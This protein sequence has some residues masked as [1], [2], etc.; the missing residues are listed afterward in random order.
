MFHFASR[1]SVDKL[2]IWAKWS[3][4]IAFLLQAHNVLAIDSIRW[5]G[6]GS[7]CAPTFGN[8]SY[9]Y[10]GSWYSYGVDGPDA[11]DKALF[12]TTYDYLGNSWYPTYIHFG[13]MTIHFDAP[14]SDVIVP[15][16]DAVCAVAEVMHGSWTFD[17]DTFDAPAGSVT[18]NYTLTGHFGD[19]IT[20]GGENYL[21]SPGVATLTV[22][23]NG[24]LTANRSTTI[25][26]STGSQGEMIVTG[27]T[28]ELVGVDIT[29][30]SYGE[31]TLRVEQQAAVTAS[32]IGY[33]AR[34]ASGS[35][36]MIVS[37][38]SSV[39]LTEEIIVGCFGSGTLSVQS[40]SQVTS[41]SG[42]IGHN[43]GA[44]GT[45]TV[46]G[47][48]SSW[49]MAGELNVGDIGKGTLNITN[50][51]TV[52]SGST[53]TYIGRRNWWAEAFGEAT[54]S[55]NGSIWDASA[56]NNFH[57]GYQG[58]GTLN[59]EQGGEV[60]CVS[61][62][63]GNGAE[64]VG[65]VTVDNATWTI[66][67]DLFVGN[68]G[69]GTLTVRNNGSVVNSD[70]LTVGRYSASEMAVESGG[71]VSN[72]KGTVA[73]QAG[74]A[75]TVTVDGVG[76]TWTSGG[77][78]YVG[79]HGNGTLTIQNGGITT[80]TAG[81]IACGSDS[82]STV[83]VNGNGS[84]WTN[85]DL[86][87]VGREGDGELMIQ[88]GGTVSNTF[89]HVGAWAGST[90]TVTVDGTNSEWNN[91]GTL[92]IGGNGAGTLT[93]QNGGTV[94]NGRTATHY[95]AAAIGSQTGSAG[96]VTIDGAGT[97]WA[98]GEDLIVANEGTGTLTVR[99]SG[100]VVNSGELTVGRYNDGEML[101]ESGATLSNTKGTIAAQAGSVGTVTVDGNGSTWTNTGSLFVG[102]NSNG[103]LSVS[104]GGNVS[105]AN[106]TIAAG[107]GSTS[108]VTISDAASLMSMA[109][110]TVGKY[111]D[112]TLLVEQQAAVTA[113]GFANIGRYAGGIGEM[114]VSG[115]SSVDFVERL[116]VGNS[117]EGTLSVQSNSL[118][119]SS[120][121]TIGGSQGSEGTANVSGSGTTWSMTG[122]L[123]VGD[124]GKGTLSITN[125]GMVTCGSNYTYIG[126]RNYWAEAFG[127]VN[128]SGSGSTW[129]AS[130]G[131]NF[132]VGYQ[133]R[134]TLN[135]EQGGEVICV[136]PTIG[137]SAEAVGDVTVDEGTWTISDNLRVGN[138]GQGTLYIAQGGLVS[139]AGTLEID[140]N[141]DGDSSINMSTGGMLAI[142]GNADA[143]LAEFFGLTN[144]TD[145]INYWDN[146]IP[147]WADMSGA[148]FC[149]DYTLNYL[150]T[151]DLSGYTLL[152]VQ[153][154]LAGDAN[155]D[156]EVDVTDLGI[157]ATNYGTTSGAEWA[158]ADFNGDG[159]VNVT[160]LG[161][162]ATMYGKTIEAPPSQAVPEPSGVVLLAMGA[163]SLLAC[164]RRKKRRL[165]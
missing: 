75:G 78:L 158:E 92:L 20:V 17:F 81:A 26:S 110:M 62:I 141:A 60:I 93:I 24:D 43:Q 10:D 2:M 138:S 84:E 101:I 129:D 40:N 19:S 13:D 32:G 156:G 122:E 51:G 36:E 117:G 120:G 113:S 31:G 142:F 153:R 121:G 163:V 161:V 132:Y 143:S 25:G 115:S 47:S 7:G 133:G 99:N 130:T 8:S 97:T 14:C 91:S 69:T 154:A 89:G 65:D 87:Y 70:E 29:A 95:T 73:S 57:V 86:L 18:G 76:S 39:D 150:S 108:T 38:A 46:S 88:G 11:D 127:E 16:G 44:V 94:T 119:T 135:I 148:M 103:T 54:V 155:G 66:S 6:A 68:N 159:K 124:V 45:A 71:T 118:V 61:P 96:T 49:T 35:G 67:N 102:S 125:G 134:G 111:G 77:S 52:T 42:T 139:V 106:T 28:T 157:L 34:H 104:A 63:V 59:I 53:H 85:S 33:I 50:G 22:T 145:A 126:R 56:S 146:S 80:N 144:G 15:G 164:A 109:D 151:G 12:D 37:D 72:T 114:V 107:S 83:T 152:T 112:G 27:S 165:S 21:G 123:S 79:Y 105:A 160:D 3:V 149:R 136:S 82:T 5:W 90:G 140:S 162:L 98:S 64:A 30:G 116:S 48:G 58:R 74:S 41:S 4:C 131:N 128:V 55:G 137:S 100:S 9:F 23:G 147:D 1:C